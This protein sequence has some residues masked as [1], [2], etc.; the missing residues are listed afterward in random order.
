MKDRKGVAPVPTAT[1]LVSTAAGLRRWRHNALC[2]T[3]DL[4]EAWVAF[5]ALLLLCVGA[6]LAGLLVGGAADA[7]LQRSARLQQ[8]QRHTVTAQVVGPAPA[9]RSALPARAE[10]AEQQLRGPVTARWTAPDGSHRTGTVTV[11]RETAEPGDTLTLWTD[12]RG[13]PVT[14]PLGPDTA[15]EHAVLAGAGAAATAA[16]LV[17]GARRLVVWRLTQRRY[18]RLDRAWAAAGPD[19]GRTGA[20]G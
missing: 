13:R 6:P 7:S 4:V 15:R 16:A 1:G 18:A 19:W 5:V 17:E 8:E 10:T 11:S 3:T 12:V 2:R 14:R 20:G 9:A